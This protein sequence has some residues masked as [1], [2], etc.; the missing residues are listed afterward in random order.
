MTFLESP[1]SQLVMQVGPGGYEIQ[2]RPLL[3][4]IQFSPRP[5]AFPIKLHSRR[6]PSPPPPPNFQRFYEEIILPNLS[7]SDD[8]IQPIT[9]PPRSGKTIGAA[10]LAARG[11]LGRV[12]YIAPTREL[13]VGFWL[14]LQT[15]GVGALL[16][17]GRG[18]GWV[19]T[20]WGSYNI[21]NCHP[22]MFPRVQESIERGLGGDRVC[23]NCT[24]RTECIY[25]KTR[26]AARDPRASGVVVTT[27]AS[28]ELLS[29]PADFVIVDEQ[30]MPETLTIPLAAFTFPTNVD[31][32]N[33]FLSALA[34]GELPPLPSVDFG[35]LR[36]TSHPA[37]PL[38]SL[39]SRPGRVGVAM[40]SDFLY[41]TR[42]P[43][44]H[45]RRGVYL[46]ASANPDYT[47]ASLPHARPVSLPFWR[48]VRA[49]MLV[50]YSRF[51]ARR[52]P[53]NPPTRFDLAVGRRSWPGIGAKDFHASA[54]F[55]STRGKGGMEGQRHLVVYAGYY[56]SPPPAQV[57]QAAAL[58][59]QP[60]ELV[61]RWK[62][63]QIGV[64]DRG[65][66]VFFPMPAAGNHTDPRNQSE[67][68]QA[69]GRCFPVSRDGLHVQV[70]GTLSLYPTVQVRVHL[71][72]EYYPAHPPARAAR[73]WR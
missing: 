71:K 25:Q 7:L 68:L 51:Q 72:R 34:G 10:R 15:L 23:E 38:F 4:W 53:G 66:E 6:P 64:T 5:A 39:L 30:I 12:L 52:L 67:A 37:S 43:V 27:H 65:A 60:G 20:P 16:H 31:E 17:L 42:V 3:R 18:V 69:I 1:L 13:A 32:V 14:L 36:E 56:L 70:L 9:A 61:A 8:G 57:A 24:Y 48:G 46:D 11:D 73:R 54:Y 63:V 28:A 41:V 21:T 33:E 22:A 59:P 47:Q 2:Q 45:Y 62:P 35:S 44:L 19:E 26:A 40:D 29:I 58:A 55:L 49:E 50:G